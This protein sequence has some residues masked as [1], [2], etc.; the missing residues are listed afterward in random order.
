MAEN[1]I[2]KYDIYSKESLGTIKEVQG[3]LLSTLEI[4][5]LLA[6]SGVKL[7]ESLKKPQGLED[8][9]KATEKVVQNNNRLVETAKQI[10]AQQ[11]KLIAAQARETA[12]RTQANKEIL[13]TNQVT[14]ENNKI[15]KLQAVLAD[16]NAGKLEKLHAA[17]GLLRI[18]KLK[19]KETD[20]GYVETMKKLNE[21]MDK[22]QAEIAATHNAEQ[23]RTAGI[24]Q[25]KEKIGELFT[26]FKMG[27]LGAKGLAKG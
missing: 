12:S 20:E 22:N 18:Q 3:E 21:E 26:S 14:A 6:A 17:Q 19:L 4:M 23:K 5:K 16:E 13:K 7:Q 24:G 9:A 25:Y 2:G 10:E 15:A 27:E 8:T 11:N 1:K